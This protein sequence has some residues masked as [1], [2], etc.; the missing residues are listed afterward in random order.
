MLRKFLLTLLVLFAIESVH[1]QVVVNEFCV[2]NYSD[3]DQGGDFEDWVEL[4]NPSG[5]AVNIGGYWLS[6]DI[7]NPMKW[8]VPAGTNVNAGA[9]L[10]ILLS[11]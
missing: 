7:S 8:Q 3:W 2:A 9:H 5:S 10:I 4:Y 1:S 6:N 11:G